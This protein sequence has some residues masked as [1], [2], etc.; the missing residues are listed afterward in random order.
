MPEPVV[1]KD[2][3][4]DQQSSAYLEGLLQTKRGLRS[5]YRTLLARRDNA[6]ADE[7]A[8]IDV[9]LDKNQSEYLKV[10]AEE[11]AYLSQNV[12]FAPPSQQ[13]VDQIKA[14]VRR[15]DGMT[16]DN[17]QARD[18]VNATTALLNKWQETRA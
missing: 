8:Y 12:K 14:I 18:I 15:I 2:K 6:D 13:D 5:A 1:E 17:V 10:D 3:A 16:A 4:T 9:E 11:K 7:T